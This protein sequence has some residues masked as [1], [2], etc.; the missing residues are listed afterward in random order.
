M[1]N[2]NNIKT[3]SNNIKNIKNIKKS[4]NNM[5]GDLMSKHYNRMKGFLQ[6]DIEERDTSEKRIILDQVIK[7]AKNMLDELETK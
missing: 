5:E 1:E 2:K 7:V 4:N 6:Y 3:I